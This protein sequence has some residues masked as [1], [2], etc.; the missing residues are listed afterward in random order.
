MLFRDS[1]LP[2]S[3]DRRIPVSSCPWSCCNTKVIDRDM[4]IQEKEKLYVELKVSLG[5]LILPW[6]SLTASMALKPDPDFVLVTV[7]KS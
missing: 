6:Q 7:R 1:V 2:K 4:M 5:E 3:G